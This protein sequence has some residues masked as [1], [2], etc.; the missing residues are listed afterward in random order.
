MLLTY[1]IINEQCESNKKEGNS[2]IH[3][4]SCMDA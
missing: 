3:Y 2:F 1:N 4:E